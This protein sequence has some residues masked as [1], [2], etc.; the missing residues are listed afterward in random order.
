MDSLKD[1]IH[2]QGY[3][4][5]DPLIEY[6]KESFDMFENLLAEIRE[7]TVILM[8]HS[9]IVKKETQATVQS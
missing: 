9:Q 3:G 8:F 7:N 1:G 2:L 5:K 6:K 4:Q